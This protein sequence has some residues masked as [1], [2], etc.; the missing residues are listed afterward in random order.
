[1]RTRGRPPHPDVLTPREWEVRE[2]LRQGLTNRQIADQLGISLDGAKY[3][4]SEILGKLGLADRHQAATWQPTPVPWWRAGTAVPAILAWPFKSLLS[5]SAPKAAGGAAVATGVTIL[6]LTLTAIG[7]LGTLAGVICL[8]AIRSGYK[9]PQRYGPLTVRRAFI[10]TAATAPLAV[11]GYL[12]SDARNIPYLVAVF[13]AGGSL[14]T[15]GM[16]LGLSLVARVRNGGSRALSVTVGAAVALVI[17]TL[18]SLS[19]FVGDEGDF[20]SSLILVGFVVLMIATVGGVLWLPVA[21]IRRR[22]RS[23]TAAFVWSAASLAVVGGIGFGIL[24]RFGAD[25]TIE[26]LE[27]LAVTLDEERDA[28]MAGVYVHGSYAF[29]GGQSTSYPSK[30]RHKQGIR[31]LDISDPADPQLVGRIPLRGVEM[32]N[33]DGEDPHS[34]GDAVATRIESAA[35][36]GDIAIVINGVPD[37]FTVD[38]YPLPYGIWDVTDPANPEFLSVLNLRGY[39]QFDREGDKPNDDKA[40]NGQYFYAVYRPGQITD[41]R[42]FRK[43]TDNHLAVVDLSDPRNPVVVGDWHDS[44]LHGVL[45]GV[46]LNKAGTRAYVVGQ[47]VIPKGEGHR[48]KRNILYVLDL[49]DPTAPLEIGRHEYPWQKGAAY[50]VPNED[51]SLVIFADGSGPCGQKAALRFLDVVD[52][53]SIHEVSVFELGGSDRCYLWGSEN[54]GQAKDMVVK[55]NLVYSTWMGGGL[56]VIDTSDPVNPVE[57]GKFILSPGSPWLSDVALYGDVVLATEIW[58]EGLYLLR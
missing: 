37:T 28:P 52:P 25:P 2:L 42:D 31:I 58:N 57:V 29:V 35:F 30:G 43:Y 34:H 1:M 36:Q 3:H 46:S 48:H 15:F 53:S 11:V 55:G 5:G 54:V 44:G 32:F 13:L 4:V 6:G 47:T 26:G 8:S 45:T 19:T 23:A 7:S 12:I 41:L 49:Q 33:T 10:V 20:P 22:G 18:I 9:I 38:E 17:I 56:R 21:L 16:A 14:V 50:A 24:I 51:D 39:H 40:V 27:L